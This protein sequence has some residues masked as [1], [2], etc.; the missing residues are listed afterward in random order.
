MLEIKQS[1]HS[2]REHLLWMGTHILYKETICIDFS[3]GEN[4]ISKEIG[5]EAQDLAWK[6]C[7]FVYYAV[8]LFISPSSASFYNVTRVNNMPLI[9][10]KEY[11][12]YS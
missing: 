4:G 6:F 7:I 12:N 10:V 11:K 2:G 1:D 8:F 5:R 9:N 3:G